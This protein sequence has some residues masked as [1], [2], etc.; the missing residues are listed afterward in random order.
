M[1]TDQK[2]VI[3]HTRNWTKPYSLRVFQKISTCALL[4]LVKENIPVCFRT[5]DR[6]LCHSCPSFVE[7]LPH[8]LDTARHHLHLDSPVVEHSL[9]E[10]PTTF[11]WQQHERHGLIA[12]EF[13]LFLCFLFISHSPLR[14]L[15][16]MMR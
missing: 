5:N 9:V 7:P 6:S 3:Y 1:G 10:S 4:S 15:R 8:C 16:G 14:L 13:F 2:W 12:F 11:S